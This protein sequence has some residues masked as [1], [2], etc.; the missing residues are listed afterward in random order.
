MILGKIDC[1]RV[2][3]RRSHFVHPKQF[4][5]LGENFWMCAR[6]RIYRCAVFSLPRKM[7]IGILVVFVLAAVRTVATSDGFDVLHLWHV[8]RVIRSFRSVPCVVRLNTHTL[9]SSA[10]KAAKFLFVGPVVTQ[11]VISRGGLAARPGLS[12]TFD[13]NGVGLSAS[14][15]CCLK[16]KKLRAECLSMCS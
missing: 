13:V 6:W 3:H 5:H 11:C 8:T 12:W 9:W 16:L 15:H 2:A 1:G 10:A 4:F 7:L 14:D